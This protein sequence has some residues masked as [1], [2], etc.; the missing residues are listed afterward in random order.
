MSS[1]KTSTG[2]YGN[3]PLWRL[4]F[5]KSVR[6]TKVSPPTV[7]A[8]DVK[9]KIPNIRLVGESRTRAAWVL[10]KLLNILAGAGILNA[11]QAGCFAADLLNTG[12]ITSDDIKI[13]Y[14]AYPDELRSTMALI[15]MSCLKQ[16]LCEDSVVNDS[17]L[18]VCLNCRQKTRKDDAH[19]GSVDRMWNR[20]RKC[21][22][23]DVR[24]PEDRAVYRNQ[25]WQHILQ[26]FD[27]AMGSWEDAYSC[28]RRP[29][30][31]PV[32]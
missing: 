29:E 14:S 8:G 15:C 2:P 1:A 19:H 27:P 4:F 13:G 9:G 21:A 30:I 7:V 5:D 20:L 28:R 31:S 24:K 26:F 16:I 3:G 22:D 18:T 6:K 23:T 10:S 25:L 17:G 12:Q 11:W 32:N